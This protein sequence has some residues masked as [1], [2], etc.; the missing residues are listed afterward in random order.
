MSN[1]HWRI[2]LPAHGGA[3]IAL[4]SGVW[5][6]VAVVLAVAVWQERGR[7]ISRARF[8]AAATTAL[9]EA[10]TANTF[11][12]VDLALQ[13]VAHRIEGQ[14]SWKRH[15]AGVRS[16][17]T[18]R[19][20]G[21]PYVRALYVIGPDGFIQHDTDFP[22][23]P[24][25]TLADRDYFQA[26]VQDRSLVRSISGPLQ[27]R[28]GLGWFVAVTRRI[29]QGPEFR[30]IAVAAIQLRYFSDLY[31]R[32]GLAAGHR[33]VLFH[34]DGRL[35]AQFPQEYGVVGRTYADYPLFRTH[36][37]HGPRGVYLS[38]GPPVP[39]ARVFSYN[40]LESQPLVVALAH[41]MRDVL[42]AWRK[43]AGAAVILL[44]MLLLLLAAAA[45]Q[46]LRS[47][48]HRQQLRD[49]IVQGEKM[50]A[51]GQL[52]GSIA[53][54]F[55][56]LLTILSTN[57]EVLQRTGAQDPRAAAAIDRARHAIDNG[58]GMTRQLLSFARQ[59]E[60]APVDADLNA[61]LQ[62]VLPLLQ[63]A[64]G[65]GAPVT[66]TPGD[67]L[68]PCRLDRNQFDAA[69]INLVVNAR[70]AM[71]GT[72][73]VAIATA[74][75][76]REVPDAAG[77][78]QLRH[79][80]CVR[81]QDDGPGMTEEVRRRALEPF[82]TTKGEAGTGLGLPQVYGLLRQLGGDVAIESQPGGGTTVELYFP[83]ARS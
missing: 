80:V 67:G 76:Q 1:R 19:L 54:D 14:S 27:S 18:E 24:D 38:G 3:V 45:A 56:N 60:L 79:F 53:H 55:G 31:E 16:L 75:A 57:L 73:N 77:R 33:I 64:A 7:E 30:G 46:F 12:V 26:H 66:F 39:Y 40:A 43:T 50:E 72:G 65:R 20:D 25:V 21:M 78:M 15:D 36:L 28:S 10:H 37:P 44:L 49:R 81:V 69:L 70:D 22:G 68:R 58:K 9:M 42:A 5:L 59:R 11:Q 71:G 2:R 47:Q 83:A 63:Q 4:A 41:D 82:F 74:N 35:I 17:M 51:L 62:A 52:T 13:E 6:L 34:R 23:T 29:G 61:V 48:A 32:I 8:S